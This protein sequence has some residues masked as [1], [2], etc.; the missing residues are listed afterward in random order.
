[1]N[2]LIIPLF[3]SLFVAEYFAR[4]LAVVPGYLA[5]LPELFSAAAFLVV[6]ARLL[7][8]KRCAMDFRYGAFLA[9][10]LFIIVFGFVLQSMTPGAV[11][12]GLRNYLKYLPFFLLPMLLPISVRQLKV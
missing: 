7:G 11:V 8:G 3:V 9:L 5:L 1:M 4:Q 2:L 12:V 6:L 10:Y